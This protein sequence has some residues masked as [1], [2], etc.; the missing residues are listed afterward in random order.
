VS[1][2]KV[3]V[4]AT[5]CLAAAAYALPGDVVVISDKEVRPDEAAGVYYLGSCAAGYLYNGSSSS[6]AR[7]AP[8]RVLDRDAQTK[9]YYI[10][11]APDWAGVTPAAFEHLGTA[12]RLSENEILIGLGAGLGPGALRAV[13]HRIELIKLEP[14][15]PAE[16]RFDG[17]APPTKKDPYIEAAV[18]SITEEE[19]AGYIKKLQDFKTRC[20][21]TPGCDAARD[22]IRNFFAAQNS[23]ASF[24][25][26]PCVE[27]R[28]GYYPA[29]PNCVYVVTDHATL[30]RTRDGG[31]TWDTIVLE[32]TNGIASSYW[33]SGDVGFV[34]GY[35]SVL[36]KTVDGGNSWDTFVIR[37]G[38]PGARYSPYGMCFVDAETGWLAGL[39]WPPGGVWR[40][41]VMKTT[42]GGRAWVEQPFPVDA[43]LRSIRFFDAS[44]GWAAEY[45]AQRT[46]RIFYT[47][48]GGTT[49]RECSRPMGGH[50]IE[51]IEPTG[52]DEAW[53]VDLTNKLLHTTDG[54]TWQYVD[55]GYSFWLNSVEFPDRK[56]GY[57][58]YNHLITTEDGG[59]TWR[60]VAGAPEMIY[61][62]MAF[63]DKDR[64]VVGDYFGRYLFQT[65]DGGKTFVNI[66]DDMD[67]AAE[68]VIGERRGAERP[69]EIV[70]IGGHFDSVSD[71]VPSLC[72]GAEDNASGT[73]C[74]MAAARAFKDLPFK[75]TVRYVAFGDEESGF[76]GSRAYA[77]YCSGKG[78]KII[79]VLNADMVCYDEDG[80]RR[81]DFVAGSG[82]NGWWMYDY[83]AAVGGLYG[84]RIIYDA[85]WENISDDWSF[86]DVGYPAIGVIEGGEGAGGITEYPY[87][88]TT[89]DTLD[90]LHPALGVRF[91]RDYAAMFAHLAGIS[92]VG[93]KDPR[94]PGAAA[95][96]FTRPFAV[97]PNPYCYATSTGGVNFVGLKSP[98]TVEIYDLAGRR[99]GREEVAGGCD[100]CVWWPAT[101]EG[102][103][104]A[105]GVYIYR[106]EGQGQRKVGKVVVAK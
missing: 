10:V 73:A 22:Y 25:Q 90:K 17:E 53:A 38:Y 68:N 102:E 94:K 77:K 82:V 15:T 92:D 85:G 44:H 71:Q 100:E 48:D 69:E 84:Q 74:A 21:D 65:A 47:A 12:I 5:V 16:W 13:E 55:T 72:P 45:A 98:A 86:E 36:A 91:V 83:L 80:G 87:Y 41:S 104:F 78:E 37:P 2:I 14:V 30:K 79:G 39:F 43:Y 46:G 27:F 4:V 11:W 62:V 23:N 67:L 93:V 28:E 66:I 9:E 19:Y 52:P 56:H 49:W 8:Y 81:D 103:A 89:E 31:S 64:G 18:N 105:P 57:A 101:P 58:A 99:V 42:N 26:F 50:G 96:P 106:V 95:V 88:H 35:N 59:A 24:F 75:R 33:V 40:G 1:T 51:E 70:I 63:A 54:T 20:T 34:A 76:I 7:V 97:Y 32:K 3:V 61:Q 60:E 29:A 6:L